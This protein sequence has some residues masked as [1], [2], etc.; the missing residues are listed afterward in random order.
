MNACDVMYVVRRSTEKYN[1]LSTPNRLFEA[2][3]AGKPVVASNFGNVKRIVEKEGIGLL[4]NPV[5]I[6]EIT[7]AFLR[8]KN[9][10]P[11]REKL[12]QTAKSKSEIYNWAT[13]QK[14]LL[15]VYDNLD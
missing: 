8:L 14:V 12:S 2:M 6:D 10:K 7:N 5:K 13:M 4:V 9:D 1:I 11:L 15:S 3:I